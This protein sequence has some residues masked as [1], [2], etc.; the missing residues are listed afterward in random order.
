M[1]TRHIDSPTQLTLDE[2]VTQLDV[3]LV[4]GKVHVVGTDGPARIEVR[5]IGHKGLTVT[6]ANG[7]LSVRHDL[8]NGTWVPGGIWPLGLWWLGRRGWLAEVI[9]AVP[10]ATATS[11][12]VINGDVVASGLRHRTTVDVTSGSIAMM[13][14]GGQIRAKTVSG[15][16]EAVGIA[17]ELTMQTVSGEISLAGSSADQVYA[18]T[19]SGAITCDLDNPRAFVVHLDTVSGSITVRVPENANLSVDLGAASGSVTSAFPQVPS[20]N[21][22]GRRSA[23][24]QIGAGTGRLRASAVSGTVSL[25][26][27][28]ASEGDDQPP[29][30]SVSPT[31]GG[32]V[33]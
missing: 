27:G 15:S 16:I 29:Q 24:G 11:L 19:I 26:A 17:G 31:T 7:S 2:K 3:W 14:L 4:H 5:R 20:T 6:Q 1:G 8:P 23:S 10:P 22:T 18:R 33:T 21:A 30:E 32:S 25:L 9:I 12:T 28:P 13:G